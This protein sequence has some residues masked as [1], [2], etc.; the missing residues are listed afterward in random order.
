MIFETEIKPKHEMTLRIIK[1]NNQA[2]KENID[3][4]R[5]KDNNDN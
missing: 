2:E 3:Y 1:R 5:N 4:D